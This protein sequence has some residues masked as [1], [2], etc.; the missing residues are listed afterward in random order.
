MEQ[1]SG[2]LHLR[3]SSPTVIQYL[4][5]DLHSL[6]RAWYHSLDSI[7][8][9]IISNFV[10]NMLVPTPG[11]PA[12]RSFDSEVNNFLRD[13]MP[14]TFQLE[15]PM[16]W[17]MLIKNTYEFGS[18]F[19]RLL[20][21]RTRFLYLN[22]LVLKNLFVL[23]SYKSL[24]NQIKNKKFYETGGSVKSF[25]FLCLIKENNNRSQY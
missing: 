24:F 12:S 1:E 22:I 10:I 4:Y 18:K 6:S 7:A 15:T 2:D 16:D 9:F 20:N 19:E 11:A 17:S 13:L 3:P 8:Q 21:V 14:I 5:L 25:K 23:K